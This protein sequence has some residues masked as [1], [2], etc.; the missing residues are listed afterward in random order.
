M[1]AKW[2]LYFRH[3]IY[4]QEVK[5]EEGVSLVTSF[6]FTR[7]SKEPPEDFCISYLSC[8]TNNHQNQWQ[9]NN[10]NTAG[11]KID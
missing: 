7:K 5:E 2:L 8:G 6:L 11:S 10:N 4:I 1:V 9:N 3:H